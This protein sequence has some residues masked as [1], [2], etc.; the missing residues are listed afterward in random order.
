MVTHDFWNVS[1]V[2]IPEQIYL[3]DGW[4]INS[5]ELMYECTIIFGTTLSLVAHK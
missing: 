5:V 4:N 2:G 1:F 3:C